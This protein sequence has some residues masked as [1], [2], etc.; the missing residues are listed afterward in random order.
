MDLTSEMIESWSDQVAE[1]EVRRVEAILDR[2]VAEGQDYRLALDQIRR[3]FRRLT[4]TQ[5]DRVVGLIGEP[6]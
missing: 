1:A 6:E 3:R 2:G 5:R 4:T